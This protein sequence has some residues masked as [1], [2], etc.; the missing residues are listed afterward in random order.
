MEMIGWWESR[1]VP[2]NLI[3]G[4]A[5]IISCIVAGVVVA[6]AFILFD[7]FFL[8]PG[9][10]MFVLIGILVYAVL[11]NLC[12]TGG[13][14]VELFVRSLWP[15]EADRYATASLA[16]G[17]AFSVLLSLAPG[18]MIGGAGIFMLVARFFHLHH[19]T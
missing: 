18:I 4:S 7:S 17:L 6:G 19:A 9:V 11:A 3:V 15:N 14:V 10:P 16:C 1:R 8:I 5:G 13:W 2:F 12:F